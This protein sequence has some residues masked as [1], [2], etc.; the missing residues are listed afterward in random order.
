[1]RDIRVHKKLGGTIED[2]QMVDGIVLPNNK[3]SK[4]AGG[5]TSI[6]NPKIA[7]LQ[8]C[9]SAPKTDVENSVVVKD[10]VAMD[11]ILKEE[12]KY[13]AG[14][15]KKII[16]SGANCLLIQKSIL[17]D[18]TNDL[19]L[20]FLAKKGIM[21]VKDIER[22]DVDFLS[23]SLGAIPVAHIDNLT[24]EKLGTAEWIGEDKLDEDTTILKIKGLVKTINTVSILVRGSNALVLDEAERSLHDALCVVRS[25]VKVRA[26]IPGGGAPEIEISQKLEEYSRT[27]TGVDSMIMKAY[28]DSLE[29]IPY[30]LAENAGLNPIQIVT[31]LRNRHN[32]GN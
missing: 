18:A 7:I 21:V 27:L 12:K 15:I 24:E 16:S 10:Y 1:M 20:H 9:L 17:R 6:K 5:P 28:A 30:T 14:L 3:P 8:F 13:I 23:R 25:L 22:D 32:N 19:S 4:S 31:D 2:T 11:R 29:I 26:L